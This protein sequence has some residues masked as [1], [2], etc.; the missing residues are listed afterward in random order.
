M[1]RRSTKGPLDMDNPPTPHEQMDPVPSSVTQQQ[2]EPLSPSISS[3]DVTPNPMTFEF[4]DKDFSFL[5]RPEI[6]HP[7]SNL[8]TP[9]PF[10]AAA[11]QPNPDTPLPSLLST[12][13]FRHAS[14]LSAQQLTRADAPPPA[15][16]IFSLLYNRLASLTLTSNTALASQESKSL[17]DLSSTFYLS[18]NGDTHLVP[19]DLRVL[20]VRLQSLGYGDWRRGISAYY[21]LAKEARRE[22]AR[23]TEKDTWRARLRDLGIRVANALVEMGDLEAAASHLRGLRKEGNGTTATAEERQ[24]EALVWLRLGNVFSARSC[25]GRTELEE[26]IEKHDNHESLTEEERKERVLEALCDMSDGQYADAVEKWQGLLDDPPEKDWSGV[27]MMQQNL[28]VC[29]LYT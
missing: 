26:G 19:W 11:L 15:A 27:E 17:S 1:P 25:L 2:Q 13:H 8:D 21:D 20:A 18:P 5:F 12:G 4:P 22:I 28:A 23:S 29:L 7:L 16:E 14:I 24:R 3:P 9:A 6:Y 10:R